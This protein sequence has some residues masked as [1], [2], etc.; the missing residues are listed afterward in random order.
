MTSEQLAI[1]DF[2]EARLAEDEAVARA[3]TSGPW[4]VNDPTFAEEITSADG[5]AV[6]AGGRWGDEASVFDSD[7]DAIH[8]ARHD[9]ARVLREVAAKWALLEEFE[10]PGLDCAAT[11]SQPDNCRQ[12]RVLRHLA[13]IHSD[14]H[15]YQ[16]AWKP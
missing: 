16:E 12:H 8:I 1:I 13:A 10:L 3:A 5:T 6:V 4:T 9:P 7:E 14:H 15:D 2:I 11:S